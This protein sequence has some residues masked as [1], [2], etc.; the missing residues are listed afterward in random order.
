[1]EL[2]RQLPEE[3]SFSGYEISQAAYQLCLANQ[4]DNIRFY[5]ADLLV[6]DSPSYDLLLMIDVIEHVEDIF[7]FLRGLKSK[8][9]YKLLHI[10]LDFNLINLLRP[11]ILTNMRRE[12]GHI[13]SFT[14][15]TALALLSETGYEVLDWF[16]TPGAIE[17][18]ST[19]R[20]MARLNP[21]RKLGFRINPELTVRL[22]GGYSLMVLTQ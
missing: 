7:G 11:Q 19:T 12:I 5:L 3:I 4:K 6:T 22:L 17:L 8:A 16:Y 14:R 13:H 20:K 18:S 10:P 21:L 1:M 2:S 15:E 9:A